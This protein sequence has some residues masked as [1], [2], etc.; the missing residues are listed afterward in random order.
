MFR[1][2]GERA[3]PVQIAAGSAAPSI[4]RS[5]R[6]RYSVAAHVVNARTY[7]GLP[8]G[9]AGSAF[10]A[11]LIITAG[12]W[13]TASAAAPSSPPPCTCVAG[14]LNRPPW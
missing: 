11:G 10:D 1:R 3:A 6:C 4:G 2:P 5:A 7:Q 12:E 9:E 13:R 14:P 8:A